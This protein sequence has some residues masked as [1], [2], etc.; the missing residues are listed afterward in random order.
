[1]LKNKKAD[2]EPL[3]KFILWALFTLIGIGAVVYLIK[4]LKSLT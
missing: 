2:M 3:I 1:M 4:F